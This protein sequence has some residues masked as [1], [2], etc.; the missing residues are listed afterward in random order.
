MPTADEHLRALTR[1]NQAGDVEAA[2]Y[3]REQ[4]RAALMEEDA[5]AANPTIGMSGLDKFRAGIGQG[6]T[7]VARHAG[8][9]VGLVGDESLADARQR[10]Q[11]LMDTGA[12]KAGSFVGEMAV[13]APAAMGGVGLLARGGG[14]LAR[15]A[16]N[17]LSRGVI[18]GAG[19]GALMA[20][21]GERGAG[22]V[23]GGAL[24]SILPG[25]GAVGGKMAR[26]VKR[27]P[28]A[29]ALLDRGVDLTPGQMNPSGFLNQLEESWLSVPGV[30]SIVKGAREN[31]QQSFQ[32]VA[33]EAASAPGTRIAKGES[34]KMLDDAYKSF[35]P[36]YDHAKG[37]PVSPYIMGLGNN[38]PLVSSLQQVV[39]S[40]GIVATTAARK[41]AE[42]ILKNELSAGIGTSD[43]VLRIRSNVRTAAR[44]ARQSGETLQQ[45][46]AKILDAAESKFTDVLDSQLPADAM[47]ALRTADSQ[48]GLYKV[49]EDAVAKAKDKPGGFTAADLSR[50]VAEGMKG[51][52][53]GSY[54]RGGG[55]P[56][57]DLANAGTDTMNVRSP[58][59]GARLAAIGL[60]VGLGAAAPGVGIPVGAGLL[61]LT[62]T[63]AGRKLAAGATP[64]QKTLQQLL[65]QSRT[66]GPVQGVLDQ[67]AR[68]ALVTGGLFGD[69]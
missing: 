43:D 52:G 17:P 42:A 56:L 50:A 20:D 31:A 68:R 23:M 60:P 54:A 45:D 6:M 8:N 13:T 4:Y 37:F 32:R 15:T 46:V 69:R 16:A 59:T 29:Q 65:D 57:R 3:I 38:I 19:H 67:Y 26:G 9:L 40:K 36:L 21:P 44:D 30:G 22:A 47:T 34:A 5:A 28:E 14:A 55:G 62:G 66:G 53:K 61:G 7:N 49:I 11:A 27:T 33:T 48:Y 10:D 63:Q 58:A 25:L 41:R 1:A 24:G 64:A 35:E 39:S 2:A 12:G 18:E 51:A